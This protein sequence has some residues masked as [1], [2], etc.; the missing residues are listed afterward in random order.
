MLQKPFFT[1]C[2]NPNRIDCKRLFKP[3]N[4]LFHLFNKN[5]ILYRK[6]P[7]FANVGR[8]Q[9]KNFPF[10]IWFLGE[11]QREIGRLSNEILNFRMGTYHSFLIYWELTS[12]LH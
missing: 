4:F 2:G 12:K 3:I 6:N 11:S 8:P 1:V 10:K 9:K 7:V 5:V